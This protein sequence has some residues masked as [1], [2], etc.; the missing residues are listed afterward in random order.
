MS[1]ENATKA[2]KNTLFLYIRMFVVMIIGLYTSRVILNT[3]GF[4]DYGIY[5]VV[6]SVVVFFSFL[7]AA[8]TN[9]TSRY[10]T[11]ELGA[12]DKRRLCETYSMAINAHVILALALFVVMEI[13]G[14]WFVNHKLVIA[15]ERMTAANWCYQFSLAVFCLSI[16]RVPFRSSVIA[17]EKMDFYAVSSIV[18]AT[19]KLGTLFLLLASPVDKLISYSVLMAAVAAVMLL[20]YII[21]CKVALMDCKYIRYWNN[22]MLRRF[23]TYS[24]YSM[25]V[26][27]ADGV[28]VQ[29][30]NVFF[31]WFTGTLANAAMGIANQVISL[32]GVF[33]DSFSQAMR[34]QIIKSYA[35]GDHR[36][37][38]QLLFSASKMNYYLF[39]LISIPV[40]L[41]LDFILALWL[42]KYPPLTEPFVMAIMAYIAFDVF[43]EPLWMAVHATGNLKVHQI[44]IASIKIMAVPITYA[45]LWLGYSPVVTLYIWAGLNLVCAIARTL[46]MRK[47]IGLDLRS[48]CRDVVLKL[49]VVTLL[50]V[51]LPLLLSWMIEREWLQLITTTVVAVTVTAGA[52]YF[53]GLS[54]TE[55]KFIQNLPALQRILSAFKK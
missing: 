39:L 37:F 55:K 34:P 2:L 13:G 12:G 5:N 43:Q 10:L 21:Y 36:Y 30:R 28:T 27:G 49:V 44:M 42:D 50:S 23:A 51:P 54:A 22:K 38:M 19:L 6:G 52:A 32:L 25:L 24:G 53:I 31:N 11:Y 1:Q 4:E 8:L 47:L 14:V 18:E 17:H 41:N 29:C 3:L 35:A 9:A 16:I 26:N 40:A 7:N 15:P 33:V 46:Y 48:Y 45:V 20:A